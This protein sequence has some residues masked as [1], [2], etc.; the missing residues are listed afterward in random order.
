[1]IDVSLGVP[2]ELGYFLPVRLAGT[3]PV[4][5]GAAAL[6]QV[7]VL[8]GR[9]AEAART[10]AEARLAALQDQLRPHFLFNTLQSIS[11][12]IHRDPEAAD[13]VLGRL[14]DLLR[15]SLAH[16]SARAIPVHEE[17]RMTEQFLG[18]AQ[19]RIGE[20]FRTSIDAQPEVA[21]AAVP[22]FILQPLVENAIHHGLEQRGGAGRVAV[23]A[24]KDGGDLILEIRDDGV[25]C[26]PDSEEGTGMR[27]VRERLRV[28][29]GD[30]AKLSMEA[31]EPHGSLVRV[32]LPL[33]SVS[34]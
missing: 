19:A 18:I 28:L 30:S 13:A 29:Y 2:V 10:A 20:K 8:R 22:P 24:R 5:V 17:L 27:N 23:S 14:A 33:E 11:T 21:G 12:L 1:V 7:L 31:V 6:G 9:A 16:R 34:T 4:I 32:R 15:A 25:G 26:G 3:V